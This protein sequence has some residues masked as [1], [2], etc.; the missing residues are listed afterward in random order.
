M[1]A[2]VY[3]AKKKD[4]TVYYRSSITFSGKHISLGSFQT[5]QDAHRT[6]LLADRILHDSTLSP[7]PEY[8]L[9]TK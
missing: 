8:L 4:G 2:G 3:K 9:P 7:Q 1:L 5:E 6:Y